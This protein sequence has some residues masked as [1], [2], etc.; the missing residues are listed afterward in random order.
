[1]DLSRLPVL[2]ACGQY[3][4]PLDASASDLCSPVDL[5]ERAV[6]QAIADASATTSLAPLIDH[7]AVVRLFSDSSPL[8]KCPQ[9]STNNLPWSI[10]KR[11][12]AQPATAI[13]AEV[14][15]NTPQRLINEIAHRIYA[16]E[17]TLGL[18]VGTE[19][20]ANSK[21]ATRE[22]IALDWSESQEG[23]FDDRGYGETTI[24]GHEYAN[25]L[26]L[27]THTYPL[28]EKALQHRK[29]YSSAE[30]SQRMGEL[31]SRFS[32]VAA[33]NPYAQ[34]P[35]AYSAQA[36]ITASEDNYPIALPYLKNLVAKD[37]VNQAAAV[38]VTSAA[39][40]EALGID[41]SRWVY[42]HGYSDSGEPV[43]HQRP[44]ISR[45]PAL[46]WACNQALTMAGIS[47]E[48]I[49]VFDLYSCFPCAVTLA[50]EALGID[51]ATD[52]RPLTLTGGL[53]YFGGAGNGYSLHAI[54]SMM[55]YARAN[56]DHF[57]LINANGGYLSKQS[58]GIYSQ[59]RPRHWQPQLAMYDYAQHRSNAPLFDKE[60]NG[61]AVIETY[62]V[63]YKKMTPKY[64]VVIGRLKASGARF[65]A[66][67]ARDASTMI[68]SLC[69]EDG[70]GKTCYV[71][72]HP[73]GNECALEPFPEP[74]AQG[75]L[76]EQTFEFCS[77]SI[78]GHILEVTINR[79]EA[80][81][82]V[83]P[84][85]NDE[86]E[87]IFNHYASDK[88]L[89]V[90]ILTGAGDRAFCAG[91]D[92]KYQAQGGKMW[93]PKTGFAGLTS[94]FDLDKPVIA[95]VNGVA[96][97]GGFEIA[98]ACDL[99]I[100]SANAS[101]SLPEPK[102]GLAALAGG[103]HRLPREIGYKRAMGMILT[104]RKVSAEEGLALGFVNEVCAQ[105]ESVLEAARRWAALIDECSPTSIRCSKA[106]VQEGLEK[107][108]LQ[109]AVAARYP[110]IKTLFS[111]KD[112]IEGPMAFA[113][114]RK[115]NWAE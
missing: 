28:I 18:V 72:S 91:N 112:I 19:A 11:I 114:K 63:V 1:M 21:R 9:G 3:T 59:R 115:P 89:R 106:M 87:Q 64:G 78:N 31:F 4:Q 5:A 51:T 54:A 20:I 14:G 62:T 113:Q 80:M 45:S 60:P 103:L 93:T 34:Y 44:D 13:Y 42:L 85:A 73:G 74:V 30:H 58:I 48:D 96:A 94:R 35:T 56:P 10:A 16:G 90:A 50:A 95:A 101:F 82:A 61:E 41:P 100:A 17:C 49:A 107:A 46:E 77:V 108:S 66:K 65:I 39:N 76:M 52:S 26:G 57:G 7:L 98:L 104:G 15:G 23:A 75:N 69:N 67:T 86:L 24:T 47:V 68:E 81:N 70:I 36:L 88:H 84:M 83:H 25:G 105:G 8:F 12:G 6:A 99:I 43:I 2:V 32:Q 97:G 27:P 22:G 40:A 71:K 33:N 110:A 53:P 102:V 111:S 55:R 29:G 79:P 92:L 37:G 109:E 38:L